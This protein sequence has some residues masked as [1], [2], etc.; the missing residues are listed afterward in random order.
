MIIYKKHSHEISTQSVKCANFTTLLYT[1]TFLFNILRL[2][3]TKI[4]S[5]VHDI[6]IDPQQNK[7]HI[8]YKMI[9]PQCPGSKQHVYSVSSVQSP[10]MKLLLDPMNHVSTLDFL[11]IIFNSQ[12]NT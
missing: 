11:S 6:V 8:I 9:G 5:F 4:D 12:R 1:V 7:K 2:E 3:V 10:T